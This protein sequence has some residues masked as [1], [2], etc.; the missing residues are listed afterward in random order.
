MRR[1]F[2]K[3]EAIFGKNPAIIGSEAKHIATVL[4]M[5]PGD[6]VL[7]FDGTGEEFEARISSLLNQEVR[8]D[9]IGEHFPK[10]ASP[11][12]IILAQALLKDK[13][14]DMLARQLTELGVSMWIP[15]VSERSVPNPDSMRFMV[16][17]E[18]WD[19]IVIEAMKQCRRSTPMRIS[20]LLT[21]TECLEIGKTC[22]YKI[23]FFEEETLSFQAV[24]NNFNQN[25]KK[26]IA[27][28]GPEGGF[29]LK[30]TEK[31]RVCGFSTASLGPRILKAETAA[32]VSSFLIQYLFGDIGRVGQKDID[33]ETT[34]D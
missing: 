19:K 20:S 1:F 21:F 17:K 10:S 26:I 23:L 8:F 13:K 32:V 16:R 2:I 30:E 11:V 33:K 6:R 31:A 5:K 24:L 34:F 15:F 29:S 4:R 25:P 3:K 9:I 28:L 22:D 12:E 27:L 7:L 14:M 18:R